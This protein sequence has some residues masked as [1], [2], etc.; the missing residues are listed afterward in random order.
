MGEAAKAVI[1]FLA[2]AG[3]TIAAALFLTAD[4]REKREAEQRRYT[5]RCY[6]AKCPEPLV[7]RVENVGYRGYDLACRCVPVE[8]LEDM[9]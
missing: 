4:M 9:P 2:V 1:V 8:G 3:F 7:G 6:R 5:A